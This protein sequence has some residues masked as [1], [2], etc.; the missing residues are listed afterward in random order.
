MLSIFKGYHVSIANE[1]IVLPFQFCLCTFVFM[2]IY[3]RL[4]GN[5]FSARYNVA[6]V[7]KRKKKKKSKNKMEIN[8][9]MLF[10]IIFIPLLYHS[11]SLLATLYKCLLISLSLKQN[12][13]TNFI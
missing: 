3:F 11:I 2:T 8:S 1:P 4:N 5:T 6:F 7:P 13:G 10:L 12:V 9:E